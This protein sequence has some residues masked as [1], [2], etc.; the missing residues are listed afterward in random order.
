ML[1][2]GQCV[3]RYD[4]VMKSGVHATGNL[5]CVPLPAILMLKCVVGA[6]ATIVLNLKTAFLTPT[7]W[8][9]T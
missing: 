1:K 5:A 9:H 3:R 6:W 8:E 2:P 4:F 7:F